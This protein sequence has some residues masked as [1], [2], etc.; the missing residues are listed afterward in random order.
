MDC[1]A[2]SHTAIFLPRFVPLV[3]R[4]AS[5]ARMRFSRTQAGSSLESCGTSWPEKAALK[6][7]A[8]QEIEWVIL[9]H[10]RGLAACK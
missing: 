10:F 8:L 2:C 4:V 9:G 7:L 6:M 1:F 5:S 3:S